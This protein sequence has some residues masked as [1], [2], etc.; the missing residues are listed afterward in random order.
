MVYNIQ[1]YINILHKH[2]QMSEAT[3]RLLG[4][5]TDLF[6]SYEDSFIHS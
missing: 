2:K 6:L 5:Q 4:K 3:K 1:N